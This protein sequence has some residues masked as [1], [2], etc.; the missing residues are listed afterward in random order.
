MKRTLFAL[1]F[2]IIFSVLM[3]VVIRG[4][5]PA[6]I[7]QPPLQVS[8]AETATATATLTRTPRPTITSQP[9]LTSTPQPTA[10]PTTAVTRIIRPAVL[11]SEPRHRELSDLM[12][13]FK[14]RFNQPMD[15][16]SVAAALSFAP[17]FNYTFAWISDEEVHIQTQVPLLPDTQYTL[18]VNDTATGQNG[19][20]LAQ[21]H[22]HT[23]ATPP[24]VKALIYLPNK[25]DTGEITIYFGYEMNSLNS[26][27][28]LGF[29]P[30]L[31]GEITWYGH[32]ELH[33]TPTIRP[34]AVTT[35]TLHFTAPLYTAE[36]TQLTAAAATS[37]NFI[38]PSGLKN[39]TPIAENVDPRRPIALIFDRPVAVESVAAAFTISPDIPGTFSL[40]EHT[41]FFTPTTG[42]FQP[43][44]HYTVTVAP[45]VRDEQ[46]QPLINKVYTWEFSTDFLPMTAHFGQGL[47]VQ[48]VNSGGRRAV[49]FRF[50]G[51]PDPNLN[52]TLH[53][54]TL[55]QFTDFFNHRTHINGQP[56]EPYL[57]DAAAPTHTWELP[58]DSALVTEYDGLY[59][60]LIPAEIPPGLYVLSLGEGALYDQML[61]VLTANRLVVKLAPHQLTAWVTTTEGNPVP[62]AEVQVWDKEGNLIV[63]GRTTGEGIWQ[64]SLNPSGPTPSLVTARKGNEWT[65]SGF[66]WQWQNQGYGQR[67]DSA[68]YRAYVYTDRPIYRPGQTVYYR[69]ILRY[70]DD[71]QIS[72]I[73]AGT[74]IVVTVRD[75]RGNQVQTTTLLSNDFGTVNGQF[76]IAEGGTLGSYSV[77]VGLGNFGASGWFKVEDYRKPDYRVSLST[78]AAAYAQGDT[79]LVTVQAD[80]FF[81]EPVAGATVELQQF[82]VYSQD[83]WGETDIPSLTGVTDS[84]GRITWEIPVN[85]FNISNDS[86]NTWGSN[87]RGQT[88]ALE[89]TVNDGDNRPVAASLS[90][91]VYNTRERVSV[92]TGRYGYDVGA[93]VTIQAQLE[94]IEHQPINGRPLT[95]EVLYWNYDNRAYELASRQTGIVTDV[96]GRATTSLTLTDPGFYKVI[97]LSQDVRGRVAY[98]SRWFYVWPQEQAN[99]NWYTGETLTLRAGAE[100]YAPGQTAQIIVESSFNGPALLTV[101]RATVRQQEMVQLTAP[102][103]VLD[104]PVQFADI[105]NVYVTLTAWREWDTYLIVGNYASRSEFSLVQATIN[106]IVPPVPKTLN[107]TITPDRLVAGPGEQLNVTIRVTNYLGDPVSAE[108]SLAMVDEAI[109][110]LSPDLSGSMLQTFY[111]QRG[112]DITSYHAYS[113]GRSLHPQVGE[114]YGGGGGGGGG[115]DE[116]PSA[117]HPRSDF[118]DTA[119]WFPGLATDANGEVTVTIA[120]PDNLTSWRLTARAVTADTQVGEAVLN[121]ITRQD[122]VL[123]PQ[124][125][126]TLTTGDSLNLSALVQ[127]FSD[128]PQTLTVGVMIPRPLPS[129]GTPISITSV[130][131]Q[132]ITLT[133]GETRIV[134]WSAEAIG[135][136]TA[137]LTFYAHNDNGPGDAVALM[138]PVRPLSIPDVTTTIGQFTTTGETQ[139]LASLL[140]PENALPNSTV[141]I[142][143]SRS[144]AGTMLDGLAYLTGFPYGCVEQ[145]MSRALPTAVVARAFNQLGLG[146]P[147]LQADL[148]AKI[149]ASIQRLYGFQHNDGGWGWWHDDNS[150]D[151]QTAWVIFG[152]SVMADAGYAIDPNVITRGAD[153]LNAHLDQMDSYTR[154]YALYSLAIAG[155]GNLDETLALADDLAELDAFSQA[156]LA[157]ALWELGETAQANGVLD[158]LATTATASGSFVYWQGSGD[159]GTYQGK[160]MASDTRT[161]ALVLSAFS[162]IRPGQPLEA[163][164]VRWLMAARRDTGWGTTNE[165]SY[166]ILG[167]T[168]HLLA[169]QAADGSSATTYGILLNGVL[170]GQ[171]TLEPGA[172]SAEIELAAADLQPGINSIELT[173]SGFGLVY[174]SLVQ[175]TYLSQTAIAAAGSVTVTRRYLDPQTHEPLALFQ[176]GDLVQVELRY[177]LTATGFYLLLED[178]LPG[179]LEPLNERLNTTSHEALVYEPP[180]Y[181]R[182]YGYN[183]KEI[184]GD[185]ISFFITEADAG[186]HTI[187]YLAR[188]V[189]AGS[190][191]AMPTEL[192]AMYDSTVWGRSASSSLTF[193][194]IAAEE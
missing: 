49:H 109:F 185:R 26:A 150:H 182:E 140:W 37:D 88:I 75:A 39:F 74:P 90:I 123:R 164:I 157:L 133:P 55:G 62:D 3:F 105:P 93:T 158:Y 17:T 161:T 171:G 118:L 31:E 139:H 9:T 154:A 193:R 66:S 27:A 70:D 32:N 147:A 143:L 65:V 81:G 183:Y 144:I 86:W 127:N 172:L 167:L 57:T 87:L 137:E 71:A 134:G 168:D 18:T 73:P 30:S 102:L 13:T 47:D 107:V 68:G 166:T 189:Q 177:T 16:A 179:G 135:V 126:R 48:V 82:L 162:Q 190:F 153:W 187:T 11:Q 92:T 163:G 14:V 22:T 43:Y 69:A 36:G 188:V 155:H 128:Q 148:T 4:R 115:G 33:F 29:E 111:F 146:T 91:P 80:Y 169:V 72:V 191:V 42:A 58:I 149:D 52:L 34:T 21:T 61:L 8:L 46:G 151:Y 76:T 85:L 121:V 24:L 7:T 60:L 100:S 84:Q 45:T 64:I 104:V 41:V 124:L 15:Q 106:L 53:S 94:T 28:A 159:D 54:L 125:P 99:T 98:N 67:G 122:V 142:E 181:W 44:T 173:H 117:T 6:T 131:T 83:Y 59:E 116:G 119:A 174:Y 108:L 89:V 2:T 160:T 129:A 145:T 40:D 132:V 56:Y 19:L 110:S 23:F 35:Y 25:G 51:S 112:D 96:S 20:T 77:A 138:L 79:V 114:T 136:G 50:E 10:T 156:G 194:A 120:L 180:S 165:T 1:A 103:T 175:R 176:V 78:D 170:V 113:P 178:Q 130:L 141:R 63:S 186:T 101:E 192:S 38:T 152:L 12:P 5:E 95:L 184:R 97:V